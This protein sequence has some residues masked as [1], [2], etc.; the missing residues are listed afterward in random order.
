LLTADAVGGVWQYAVDLAHALRV[1]DIEPIVAVLGPPPTPDQR[2][3]AGDLR[4]IETG[5]PLDWLCGDAAPVLAAGT[6]IAEV[7]AS[8]GIDCIQLNMPTL[9]ARATFP[10]PVVAVTH[11]CVSTWWEAAQDSPLGADYLWHRK[12]MAEGLHAADLVVAPTAAYGTIIARHYDL[13]QPPLTVH[14]GRRSLQSASNAA[15]HDHVFTAGRLWDRVKNASVL[16]RI[17]DRLAV[18]FLAAGPVEGPHGETIRLEALHLLGTLSEQSV[19]ERLAPRPVFVS[20]AR[21]E[22]FGL[23][24]LEAASAGCALVLSDI[25]TFRELWEGVAIFVPPDDDRG[26][27]HAIDRIIGNQSLRVS[28]GTAA[29]N[30]ASRFTPAAA[31]RAMA[32]AFRHLAHRSAASRS[33]AAA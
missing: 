13:I 16:D 28:L 17:A 19:A 4:V 22:P 12:L 25:P 32:R 8:E 29:R 7:A 6:A 31:A 10:V 5:L 14:N 1:E 18:P 30:R 2:A 11:G 21:F 27:A 24:V 9:G 33:R 20:A 26:F 3:C 23:A 15:M